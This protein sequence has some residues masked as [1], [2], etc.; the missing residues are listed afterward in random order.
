MTEGQSLTVKVLSVDGE[1]R[2]IS[3]GI[4]WESSEEGDA[5]VESAA[6]YAGS[7]SKSM[8]TLGDLLTAKGAGKE[9]REPGKGK[10]KR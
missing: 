5:P 7:G 8:G 4:Q 6:A 3:L 1:A 10:R 9:R 2:R